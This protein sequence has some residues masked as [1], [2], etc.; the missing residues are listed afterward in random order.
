MTG[1][2]ASNLAAR[3]LLLEL[4]QQGQPSAA[5]GHDHDQTD[6]TDQTEEADEIDH[7]EE[8]GMPATNAS[9]LQAIFGQ[10]PVG[11]CPLVV[12]VQGNPKH[13]PNHVWTG[14]PWRGR[15]TQVST[16]NAYF[17]LATY[18]PHNGSYRHRKIDC[19]RVF[20]LMLDDIG[21]KA[22]PRKR[23]DACP[24]TYLIETSP[25]NYQAG[26]LF[27][28]PQD[29]LKAVDRL[30]EMLIAA[31]LCDPGATSP[32]TRYSRLPVGINGKY[33][34]TAHCR[35]VEWAP[36]RRYCINDLIDGLRLGS[37][38]DASAPTPSASA[39]NPR[40]SAPDG[41]EVFVPALAEN[42]VVTALKAKGLHKREIAP[43]KHDVT[44]PWVKEHT[45]SED[46]GTVYFEPDPAYPSGGFRCQ[47]SHGGHYR[48]REL[49]QELGVTLAEARNR[50]EVRVERGEQHLQVDAGE[51]LLTGSGRYFQWG[52]MIVTIQA[53]PQWGDAIIKPLSKPAL[54]TA[55]SRLARWT[56]FNARMGEFV[57]CD[58]PPA[59][60]S[61]LDEAERYE[62]LPE[63][64]GVAR[65]PHL[66]SD[67]RLVLQA[68]FDAPTGIYG[69]FDAGAFDIVPVPSREDA[70]RALNALLELLK[71]FPFKEPCD[72]AAAV[73]AMLT[74]AVRPSLPQAPLFHVRAPQ[75]ASGKSYLTSL[76]A[77]FGGPRSA[78]AL[79]FPST[80][81]E[82]AKVLLAALMEG[83]P[84]LVFDNLTEDLRP[85]KA[86]CSAL[87]EP[88][89]AGRK[90]G[91]SKTVTVSTRCLFLSSGNNVGPVGDMARRC[92]TIMLDPQ[93]EIPAA[94]RFAG[95][96]LSAVRAVRGTFV[97]HA[98]TIVA[99]FA[100]AG[101]PAQPC[102]SLAT[103]SEWSLWVRQALI[104][105][106]LP[107]PAA[108]AFEQVQ[109]D[110]ER[111]L[112][113]QVLS[114]LH[115]AFG[116]D[117]FR[118][119][120]AVGKAEGANGGAPDVDLNDALDAIPRM[121]PG[122]NPRSI[123]RWLSRHADQIVD[124]RAL[125]RDGGN[126]SVEQWRV[127]LV[128]RA[129]GCGN[130][131][132]VGEDGADRSPSTAA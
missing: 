50:P 107:D 89:L 38:P 14:R 45:D 128:A 41:G 87:T 43:G 42:P 35:L 121:G 9:F 98:L 28:Q 60:I 3:A 62:H 114:S 81:E 84:T 93:L 24:P 47:H 52:G 6:Q 100:A 21:T 61:G 67:G 36:Q 73:A 68:G 102:R 55:L 129:A 78:G 4:A 59:C 58:P 69:S 20:G 19:V 99:A 125:R 15:R 106:G 127:V 103:F 95:D 92:I 77:A 31:G 1:P 25:G 83:T 74:A 57:Q 65:Q 88:Q 32:A 71:E 85:F 70:A 111:D 115:R 120:S 30:N 105:L 34:P 16:G 26:Y 63:L 39:P 132:T 2:D 122:L 49:L 23:L 117:P 18:R 123:G 119:R 48:L 110:P 8:P 90:L 109:H 126:R 53:D 124:G 44:C 118:V 37:D 56:K 101:R 130:S 13:A 12:T 113:G 7:M 27:E 116:S 40:A 108:R 64:R 33:N 22:A 29:N 17:T 46:H 10:L 86:L 11:E 97:S 91:F 76:I 104:W 75:I 66:A 112:L 96:P 51:R 54:G 5:R 94:R 80:D 82:C 72:Q 79:A 131:S